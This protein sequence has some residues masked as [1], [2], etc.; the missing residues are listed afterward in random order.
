MEISAGLAF[1]SIFVDVQGR[2]RGVIISEIDKSIYVIL[3]QSGIPCRCQFLLTQHLNRLLQ[4]SFNFIQLFI[5]LI[6]LHMSSHHQRVRELVLVPRVELDLILTEIDSEVDF[7]LDLLFENEGD[8]ILR[9]FL[10]GL[11]IGLI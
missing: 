11:E 6:V 7:P 9:D 4:H 8:H 10:F 2:L 3:L 1:E 5:R